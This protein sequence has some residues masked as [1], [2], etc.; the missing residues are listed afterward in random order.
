MERLPPDELVHVL[1][2][3]SM[4]QIG[5]FSVLSRM[6][7]QNV[8]RALDAGRSAG[9]ARWANR[10]TIDFPHNPVHGFLSTLPPVFFTPQGA[11]KLSLAKIYAIYALPLVPLTV[12]G[13]RY[14]PMTLEY[15]RNICK[16]IELSG[17]NLIRL[18][19]TDGKTSTGIGFPTLAWELWLEFGPKPGSTIE[20]SSTTRMSASGRLC[21]IWRST[22]ARLSS[23]L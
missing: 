6:L 9:R 21:R 5:V 3:L 12:F 23:S 2:W 15:V 14:S 20:T 22:K 8:A 10:L 16:A 7:N 1:R 4:C 13:A 19:D 17:E 11:S 18:A